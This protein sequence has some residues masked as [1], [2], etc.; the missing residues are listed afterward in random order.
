MK[1]F[2]QIYFELFFDNNESFSNLNVAG[3]STTLTIER[4]AVDHQDLPREGGG[5]LLSQRGGVT[6][7]T[8]LHT[9]PT[10]SDGRRASHAC[11]SG[12]LS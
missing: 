2:D 12:V 9:G 7:V 1:I 3:N 4:P 5:L 11:K 10:E 6:M 8:L